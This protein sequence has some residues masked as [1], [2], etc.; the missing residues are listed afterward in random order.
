[1]TELL[2]EEAKSHEVKWGY[3]GRLGHIKFCYSAGLAQIGLAGIVGEN[4][5]EVIWIALILFNNDLN[6]I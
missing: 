6:K 2:V 4:K 5:G 1:M 3:L